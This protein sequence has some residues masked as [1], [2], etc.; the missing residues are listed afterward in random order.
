MG[1]PLVRSDRYESAK[2][3]ALRYYQDY[4]E[5]SVVPSAISDKSHAMQLAPPKRGPATEDRVVH[6]QWRRKITTT[7]EP[8]SIAGVDTATDL[9]CPHRSAT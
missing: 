5:S 9:F 2:M 6:R 7:R 8:D 4:R 1:S 3:I